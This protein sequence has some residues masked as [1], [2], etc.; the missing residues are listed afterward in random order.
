[1]QSEGHFAPPRLAFNGDITS[2]KDC[3]GTL[4]VVSEGTATIDNGPHRTVQSYD[5]DFVDHFDD[6]PVGYK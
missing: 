6:L 4:H 5:F 2:L 3:A 1:M